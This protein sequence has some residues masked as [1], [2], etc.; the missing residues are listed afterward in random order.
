MEFAGQKYGIFMFLVYSK[1]YCQCLAYCGQSSVRQVFSFFYFKYFFMKKITFFFFLLLFSF[2]HSGFAQNM[3]EATVKKGFVI[4]LSSKDYASA[5][6]FAT[7]AAEKLGYKL[8]LRD[9]SPHEVSGLTF[10]KETCENAGFEY[11]AYVAR[12][13]YDDG[14]YVS[15]EYSSAFVGFSPGYY[16]VVTASGDKG[17]EFMKEG[18]AEAKKHYKDAY[19]KYADVYVGC[20]H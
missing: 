11:P 15:I 4:I 18:L 10:P 12:G 9:L 3:A 17:S 16:I 6:R 1:N 19:P 20:L 5:K 13:R 14:K 2:Q 8:D 7:Q